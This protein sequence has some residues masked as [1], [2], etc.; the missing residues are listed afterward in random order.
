MEVNLVVI[1]GRP[2]G[3][4]I[5]VKPKRFVIG[6]GSDCQLRPKSPT[7]SNYHCAI[8][9]SDDYVAIQDLGSSNGTLV[10]DRCL[11]R[12]EEMR[13]SD[14]DR[15]QVGQLIFTVRV[16]A[17]TRE[18]EPS[19]QDWLMPSEEESTRDENSRTLLLSAMNPTDRATGVDTGERA[20]LPNADVPTRFTYRRFDSVR[21]VASIGMSQAHVEG[22]EAIR[23]LRES[24]FGLAS[25]PKCRR[26][27][28][29]MADVYALPS[30]AC[31]L[32]L[33]LADRWQHAGGA[34]RLCAPDPE[35][36]RLIVAL[37]LQTRI[38]LFEDRGK[39]I[40]APWE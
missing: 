4:V 10:N 30:A 28:L 33:A 7:V 12:D 35:V 22:P 20:P 31:T 21:G 39:A 3:A 14:G 25:N 17:A 13:V 18:A 26:L 27:V 15:L 38:G 16:V 29:D 37:R 8:L 19:L 23:A 36:R 1:E 24:L 32:L 6:R 5:P 11:R 40:S 34:V 9:R 2:Q